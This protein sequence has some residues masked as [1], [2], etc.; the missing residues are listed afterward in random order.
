MSSGVTRADRDVRP[1]RRIYPEAPRRLFE[2]KPDR[3]KATLESLSENRGRLEHLLQ[4]CL[5]RM[6]QAN[7]MQGAEKGRST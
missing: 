3:K 6:L 1:Y 7:R 4:P 5:E 2:L